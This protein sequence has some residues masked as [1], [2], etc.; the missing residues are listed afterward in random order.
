MLGNLQI[1]VKMTSKRITI[2]VHLKEMNQMFF[3]LENCTESVCE[4]LM[5]RAWAEMSVFLIAVVYAERNMVSEIKSHIK[6]E[7]IAF[8]SL[9]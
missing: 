7:E 1:K 6:L 5:N 2:W 3:L 4:V 8:E 9:F